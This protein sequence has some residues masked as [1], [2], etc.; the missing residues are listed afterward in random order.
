MV[1]HYLRNAFNVQH[2]QHA[3]PESKLFRHWSLLLRARMLERRTS[4]RPP[5]TECNW[6]PSPQKSFDEL[7][8]SELIYGG[9]LAD[10]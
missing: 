9:S 10:R 5:S 6:S 2:R 4:L 7:A 1:I 3:W 8:I